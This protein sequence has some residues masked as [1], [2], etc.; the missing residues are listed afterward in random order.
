MNWSNKQKRYII[1]GC[2]TSIGINTQAHFAHSCV[3][4]KMKC[5]ECDTSSPYFCS[6]FSLFLRRVIRRLI[7]RMLVLSSMLDALNKLARIQLLTPALLSDI[8]NVLNLLVDVKIKNSV[9]W[10]RLL[11]SR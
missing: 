2:K 9:G 7:R 10:S 6:R 3:K 1:P 4:K 8:S 5:C 11:L